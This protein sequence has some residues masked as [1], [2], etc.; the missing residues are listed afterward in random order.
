MSNLIKL[1]A[2]QVADLTHQSDRSHVISLKFG[3]GWLALEDIPSNEW[4]F[5]FLTRP[6]KQQGIQEAKNG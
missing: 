1:T 3:S 2:E 4:A 5:D 6:A